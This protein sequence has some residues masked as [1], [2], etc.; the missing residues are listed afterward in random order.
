MSVTKIFIV[1]QSLTYV[2]LFVTLLTVACQAPLSSTISQSLFKFK[3]FECCNLKKKKKE[4]SEI[5]LS[6]ASFLYVCGPFDACVGLLQHF[7]LF[8]RRKL[9]MNY[10]HK[11]ILSKYC[12]KERVTVHCLFTMH[13]LLHQIL[14]FDPS[15]QSVIPILQMGTRP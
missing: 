3:S 8:F 7:C 2:Q 10:S 15:Y 14:S 1:I 11:L 5:G 12:Q 4:H 13:Q 6:R 9:D